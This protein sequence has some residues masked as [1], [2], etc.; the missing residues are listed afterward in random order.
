MKITLKNREHKYFVI[1]IRMHSSLPRFLVKINAHVD[2]LTMPTSQTLP[3]IFEQEKLSHAFFH[4]SIQTLME[5]FCFLK[6]RQRK[7]SVLVRVSVCTASCIYRNDQFERFEKVFSCG[8]LMSQNMHLLRG[9]KTFV[10][11]LIYFHIYVSVHTF[12][13]AIFGS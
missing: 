5:S 7:S 9:L 10:F 3:D 4:K 2:R 1:H 6:V 12:P 8:K 11:Q 13:G